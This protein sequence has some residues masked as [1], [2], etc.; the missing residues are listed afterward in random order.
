MAKAEGK[1]TNASR[2]RLLEVEEYERRRV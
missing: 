2:K 1:R